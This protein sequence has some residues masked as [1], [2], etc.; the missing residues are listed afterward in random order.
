MKP[1]FFLLILLLLTLSACVPAPMELVPPET[2]A[3][4]TLAARPPTNTPLPTNTPVPSDT[5]T[6]PNGL[7]TPTLDLGIPGA[8]CLPTNTQRL[9]GLVTKV[10]SGDSIE[11]LITNQTYPVRY[12]GVDAPSI[13]APAEWQGPQAFSF[14]QT[15]VEGKN[16]T[17]VQ[18]V[19]D[20][21]A[22]GFYPRYVLVDG[23]FI[24]YDIILQGYGLTVSV[25]PDTACANSLL[26][27]VVEAQNAVRGVW[28][29]TPVP[30]ATITLTPTITNTPLPPTETRIPVCNC[31]GPR[32]TCNDFPTQNRAQQCF[33][34]C[35]SQGF[36]D[37][38]GLDK[39]GNGLA[40]EGSSNN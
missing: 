32:L 37:V 4:Q 34:Y 30:T 28:I 21:D 26:A 9:Q 14:N 12:I 38:F 22:E 8:Y 6:P 7:P 20:R 2:L 17:L 1:W 10:L 40:C 35:R 11:V 3:A 16:V 18:D 15:R 24:N 31:R 25:P 33:E 23:A 19:T 39:N 27:A 13:L 36:G 29:P 5:P